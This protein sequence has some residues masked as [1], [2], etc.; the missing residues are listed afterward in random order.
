MGSRMKAIVVLLP[1]LVCAMAG[2]ASAA[3]SSPA[4]TRPSK[5]KPPARSTSAKRAVPGSTSPAASARAQKEK[6]YQKRAKAVEDTPD[7]QW[8]LAE[9]CREQGLSA[10]REEHMRRVIELDP[11]HQLARR[12]LGYRKYQGE[13]ATQEEIQTSRGYVRYKGKWELPQRVKELEQKQKALASER[14]WMQTIKKLRAGLEDERA[15]ESLAKLKSINDPFALKALRKALVD[16]P[17]PRV[18]LHYLSAIHRIGTPEAIHSLID[19]SLSDP[20]EEVRL[21]TIEYLAE[22]KYPEV[23]ARYIQSLRSK[24]NV[25]I[26]RAA[27]GLSYMDNGAAVAPLVDALVSTHQFAVTQ[28]SPGISTTFGGM[29]RPA[30]A[31]PDPHAIAPPPSIGGISMGQ[32][33]TIHTVQMRNAAVLD[34]LIKLTGKNFDYDI[35]TWKAWLAARKPDQSLDVRRN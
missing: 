24:D 6:E 14:Q 10:H 12:A 20:E 28:G 18:R 17:D 31:G 33:T 21:T 27:V 8:K 16:E 29:N 7:G 13:W 15:A 32:S 26:N 4:T 5:A 22:K 9:W 25:E 2:P 3:E 34:A 23:T 19:S 30:A 1:T 35:P 11:D